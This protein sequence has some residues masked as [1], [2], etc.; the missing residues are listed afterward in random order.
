MSNLKKEALEINQVELTFLSFCPI[1]IATKSFSN[2]LVLASAT[3]VT[4]MLSTILTLVLKRVILPKIKLL[5]L[6]I[7]I[8]CSATIT[9]LL[10]QA[11]TY[12]HSIILESF[13]PLIA[14][15]FLI[16]IKME[17]VL[18]KNNAALQ[19]LDAAKIGLTGFLILLPLGFTRELVGTGEVFSHMDLFSSF[20][21]IESKV[22]TLQFFKPLIITALPS[23]A[24]IFSG[25]LLAIYNLIKSKALNN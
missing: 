11:Y 3:M 25:L 24:F 17:K 9:E 13:L 1:L 5:S 6:L 10:A 22:T 8:S 15:N 18:K 16:L 2:A 14:T 12:E 23:G 20:A 4:L 19:T 7:I 21:I